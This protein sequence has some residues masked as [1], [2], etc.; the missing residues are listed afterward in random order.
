MKNLKY[1]LISVLVLAAIV[2]VLL[3]NKS[4]INAKTSAVVNEAY[5]VSTGKVSRQTLNENISFVGT[6]A[7]NN[8]VNIVSETSGK[9]TGLFYKVGEYKTA[10]S[11]LVQVDDELKRANYNT[12]EA[13]Y[14]KSKKDYDRYKSLFEQKSVSET[15]LDQMKL[16]YVNAETQYTIAKRQLSDTKIT[17]PISGLVT[18]RVVDVGTMIS[19]NMVIGNVVDISRLKVKVSIAEKDVFKLKTGDKV[20]ITT[21]I[22]PG[23]KFSG[24]VETI[25]AKGDEAHT[26]PVEIVVSNTGKHQLKAGMFTRI[27]FTS[28]RRTEALTV[29]RTAIFGSIKNSQVFVLGSDNVVKLRTIITGAEFGQSVEVL[30]GLN[31]GEQVVVSGQNTISDNFKVTVINQ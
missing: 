6:V 12:A 24:S 18:S 15:V 4:K 14:Q 28:L 29:P 11:V 22:F 3:N 20:E 16:S 31:E 13:N 21:E 25:G 10:G 8:D 26:Y 27:E 1:I 2:A 5:Y 9:V 23:E 30:S 17:T 19:N 7:A